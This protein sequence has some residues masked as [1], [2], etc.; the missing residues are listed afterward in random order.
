MNGNRVLLDTNAIAALLQGN[1][2]LVEILKSSEWIGISVISEIEFLA[3]PDLDE[4]DKAIFTSFTNRIEVIDLNHNE[5]G[6]LELILK[7][8][9]NAKIKLPDAIIASTAIHNQAKL[10]TSDGGFRKVARL[11]LIEF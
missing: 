4:N 1:L 8:R 2:T 7:I 11:K 10:I 5:I 3:N 9:K 6:L